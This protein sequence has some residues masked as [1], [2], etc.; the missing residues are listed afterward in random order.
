VWETRVARQFQAEIPE[1][2][3]HVTQL[4]VHV[5]PCT[6]CGRRVQGRPPQQSSGALG[7]AASRV[8]P[9]ALALAAD[10]VRGRGV[11]FGRTSDP[12]DVAFGLRPSD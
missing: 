5:G 10:L 7:A 9:R 6:D 1:V 4:N 8:G 12:F 2:G 11:S 3:P